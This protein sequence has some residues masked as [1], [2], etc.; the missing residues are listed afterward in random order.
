MFIGCNTHYFL[1]SSDPAITLPVTLKKPV[2][3]AYI[4][5]VP[6]KSYLSASYGRSRTYTA[7]IDQSNRLVL[8]EGIATPAYKLK[9]N[10][11]RKDIPKE[12]VIKFVADYLE[13][14]KKSG[15]EEIIHVVEAVKDGGKTADGKDT[16][17]PQLKNLDVDYYVVGNLSPALQSSNFITVFPH[18]FSTLFSVVSLGIFPSFQWGNAKME[19]KV[20]DKNLNQVWE[21]EYDA[22]YTVLRAL[23]APSYPKE[24]EGG[25][26]GLQ[27]S[28][29]VPGLVYK[30]LI[31]QV[32]SDLSGFLADK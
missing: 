11:L 3:I 14:T 27:Q 28:G 32:E 10:G 25:A 22:S 21:K 31:P 4:G 15:T 16:Y 30:D 2:K 9:A 6:F 8:S 24:C 5:F 12:K 29:A 19:V 26:C 17:T 20:Y 13:I 7:V 23:W 18:L 1:K